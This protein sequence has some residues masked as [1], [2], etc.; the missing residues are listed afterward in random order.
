MKCLSVALA[1]MLVHT[2][3]VG[4]RQQASFRFGSE[5]EPQT[6]RASALTELPQTCATANVSPHALLH[7]RGLVGRREEK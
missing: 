6:S 2:S 7:L 1:D 4:F 3:N 5:I